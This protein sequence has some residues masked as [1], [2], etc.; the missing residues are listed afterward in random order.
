MLCQKN[1]ASGSPFIYSV[2]K[3]ISWPTLLLFLRYLGMYGVRQVW[4]V[5]V[6]DEFEWLK[7]IS[8]SH[9]TLNLNISHTILYLCRFYWYCSKHRKSTIKTRSI[10]MTMRNGILQS[11]KLGSSNQI[12]GQF[13]VCFFLFRL[14]INCV[15]DDRFFWSPMNFLVNC[16]QFAIVVQ[17][18]WYES[19]WKEINRRCWPIEKQ[20]NVSQMANDRRQHNSAITFCCQYFRTRMCFST[21]LLRF[22]R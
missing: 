17:F 22:K 10:T 16:F 12:F 15:D 7:P 20:C 19:I 8:I 9:R 6:Y 11:I 3:Q 13:F 5:S 4:C 2:F 21:H 18:H 1:K 14:D